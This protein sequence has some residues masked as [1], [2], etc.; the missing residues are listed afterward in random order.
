MAPA[1]CKAPLQYETLFLSYMNHFRLHYGI[2]SPL[3][4]T[5]NIQ[6]RV[7]HFELH[8]QQLQSVQYSLLVGR[9]GVLEK[10]EARQF[11]IAAGMFCHS[12][13]VVTTHTGIVGMVPR[14]TRN[15]DIVVVVRGVNVPLILRRE[16]D[17]EFKLVGQAYFWGFMIVD[18]VI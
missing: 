7:L 3:E 14:S 6:A 8:A 1:A 11:K 2:V 16:D 9:M 12:L 5:E 18:Q 13:R 10:E 15:D 4:Y 17:K